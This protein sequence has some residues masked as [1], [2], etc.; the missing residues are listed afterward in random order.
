MSRTV[1]ITKT[2]EKKL[3]KLFKYLLENWSA[4]VK[5]DFVKKLD[6]N[7]NLIKS[8]PESF[9]QSEKNKGMFKCVITKQTTLFYRYTSE[10]ITIVTIFDT[11][12]NPI[13]LKRIKK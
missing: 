11:R 2:A 12:Q 1:I 10:S 4:K 3:D 7:V 13:K 6:R 5:S 8:N 9:P